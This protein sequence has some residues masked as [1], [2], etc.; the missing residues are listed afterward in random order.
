[1][2]SVRISRWVD[3]S[4]VKVKRKSVVTKPIWSGNNLI[5]NGLDADEEITIIFPIQERIEKMTLYGV[6]YS[7]SFRGNTVVDIKPGSTPLEYLKAGYYPF[8][9]RDHMK[10]EKA[11]M[12][13][14]ERFI[15]PVIL[16]W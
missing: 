1:M 2:V 4:K 5:C 16:P 9:V 15:S 11:P 14:K 12:K 6:D 8:Y 13:T 7:F 3:K 10:A